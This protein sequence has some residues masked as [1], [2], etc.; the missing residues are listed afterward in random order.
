MTAVLRTIGN[1]SSGSYLLK[2]DRRTW[3]A[4]AAKPA[5]HQI[6][7]IFFATFARFAFDVVFRWY[8]FVANRPFS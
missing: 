3:N 2:R 8:R 4:K 6:Q 5:K 1:C 7:P